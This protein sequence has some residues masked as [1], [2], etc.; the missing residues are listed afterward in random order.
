ME[1]QHLE[2][3]DYFFILERHLRLL[4]PYEELTE[5]SDRCSI[6]HMIGVP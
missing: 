6:G 2:A 5:K 1:Q 4:C 3:K